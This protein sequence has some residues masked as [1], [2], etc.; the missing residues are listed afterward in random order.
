MPWNDTW[1]DLPA[2]PDIA[3]PDGTVYPMTDTHIMALGGGN[4]L[5]LVG[6]ENTEWNT[7]AGRVTRKVWQL[8]FNRG[9]HSY[10]WTDQYDS[11]MGKCR[12]W[13]SHV[14][15]LLFVRYYYG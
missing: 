7:G 9:N 11:D 13:C 5:H 1:I 10:Q 8:Q 14:V 3:Y 6:G 15:I 12:V 2:L 4:R